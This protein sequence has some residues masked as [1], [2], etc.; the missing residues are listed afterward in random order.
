M[1]YKCCKTS[2]CYVNSCWHV[3][4]LTFSFW[5]FLIFLK[6]IFCSGIS[7][8][9]WHGTRGYKGLSEI[10]LFTF[11]A[12]VCFEILFVCGMEYES[13]FIPLLVDSQSLGTICGK[14][15]FPHLFSFF[16]FFFFGCVACRI[17]VPWPGVKLMPLQWKCRVFTTGQP[18]KPPTSPHLYGCWL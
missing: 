7:W 12:S 2:K 13:S 10:L 6:N 8:I 11:K 16:L 9:H 1:L 14:H 17:L 15:H 3:V 5:K 18:G 4:N